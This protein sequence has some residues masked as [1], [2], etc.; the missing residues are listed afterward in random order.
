MRDLAKPSIPRQTFLY[1]G[2]KQA[3]FNEKVGL[4]VKLN[5]S[6]I[7]MKGYVQGTQD[8]FIFCK[9]FLCLQPWQLY[10]KW[11]SANIKTT[12]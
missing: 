10:I 6:R 4:P 2:L 9:N 1:G 11:W 7:R 3:S 12:H 8:S 5:Q